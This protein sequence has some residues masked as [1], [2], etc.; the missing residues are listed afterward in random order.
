MLGMRYIFDLGENDEDDVEVTTESSAETVELA[1]CGVM[2]AFHTW[3]SGSEGLGEPRDAPARKV[4]VDVVQQ[5]GKY[6]VDV[7][8]DPGRTLNALGLFY[9]G[10]VLHDA[11]LEAWVESAEAEVCVGPLDRP[12]GWGGN[13][14]DIEA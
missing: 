8:V 7:S 10:H 1:P 4:Y 12:T 13:R 14:E 3:L 6:V 2:L 5:N 9:I 11:L